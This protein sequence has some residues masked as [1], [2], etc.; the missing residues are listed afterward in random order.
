[1]LPIR[2]DAPLPSRRSVAVVVVTALA[3]LAFSLVAP[4]QAAATRADRPPPPPTSSA[5]RDDVLPDGAGGTASGCHST[6]PGAEALAGQDGDDP[7]PLLPGRRSGRS[8]TTT[9]TRSAC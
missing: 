7:R 5:P 8:S 3:S 6:G 9:P 1:M 2:E 4:R